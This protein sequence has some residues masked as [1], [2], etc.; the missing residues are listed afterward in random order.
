[1][2]RKDKEITDPESLK[3]ILKS[4]KYVTLAFSMHDQA[5]L[6][7]LSHGYDEKRNCIYFHC[8][9]EGKKLD[10]IKSNSTIWGQAMIDY[11][12]AEGQCNHLYASVHFQGKINLLTKL[13]DKQKAI[14]CMIRQLEKNPD[15]LLAKLKTERLQKTV[16]GRISITY[17]SG[18]KSEE[19]TL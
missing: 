2:R 3:K 6:V 15:P 16:F 12:Y 4:S 11:G 7:T 9:P 18:K 1:M 8:A 14:E 5:Y 10:F 13:E 19:V 17:L